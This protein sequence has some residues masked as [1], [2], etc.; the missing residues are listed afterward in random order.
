M[1]GAI[2]RRLLVNAVVDPDEAATRLPAGVR[3]HVTSEGTVV[4]CCLLEVDAVRPA[5][6]P[7]AVGHRMR[8]AAHRI[9]VDWEDGS[10][11]A[12]TGVYVPLRH[13][14]SPL[15]VRLGGRWYP[16]VHEPARVEL[17]ASESGLRWRSSPVDPSGHGIRV[18]VSVPTLAGAAAEAM[19]DPVGATCLAAAVGLSP[20]H[21]GVLEAVRMEPSHRDAC[22]VVVEDV[23]SAFLDSF[24]S[25]ELSTSYL[26]R[27]A[28]VTWT[29]AP[30]PSPSAGVPA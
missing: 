29:R 6:L 28:E 9:S 22:A 7:R 5:G 27:D 8:A 13:T 10:G 1:R 30:A 18:A 25:A 4:G 12:T 24:T 2:L 21:H 16:G 26:L 11:A 15:A 14:T 23:E 20:D 17:A 3:P 19:C